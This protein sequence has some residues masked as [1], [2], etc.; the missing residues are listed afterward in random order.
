[1]K[2][3]TAYRQTVQSVTEMADFINLVGWDGVKKSENLLAKLKLETQCL[4][5]KDISSNLSELISEAYNNKLLL[6]VAEIVCRNLEDAFRL[7]N[8]INCL[9]TENEEVK[10]LETEAEMFLSSSSSG[11]IFKD[12]ETGEFFIVLSIGFAPLQLK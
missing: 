11:D 7:S 1:M 10:E 2:T 9:W 4:F 5:D 12:N 6:P 8:S 3:F